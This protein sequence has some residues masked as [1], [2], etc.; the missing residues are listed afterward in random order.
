LKEKWL[1]ESLFPGSKTTQKT[2]KY[3]YACVCVC[4][5]FFF[6]KEGRGLF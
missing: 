5:F 4:V 1:E 3:V 6:N 2:P